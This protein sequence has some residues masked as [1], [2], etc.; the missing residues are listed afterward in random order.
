MS[1][2]NSYNPTSSAF[3]PIYEKLKH[4]ADNPLVKQF[5]L[6]SFNEILT[7]EHSFQKKALAQEVKTEDGKTKKKMYEDILETL[8]MLQIQ[9]IQF[10][11][12]LMF[13]SEESAPTL[14]IEAEEVDGKESKEHGPA[15]KEVKATLNVV[16]DTTDPKQKETSAKESPVIDAE[17]NISETS[18][19]PIIAL[20]AF[21]IED[22]E[23]K[24]IM[25]GVIKQ[26]ETEKN[27][28]DWLKDMVTNDMFLEGSRIK[29]VLTRG[30]GDER[31]KKYVAQFL[32]NPA[33]EPEKEVT[34]KSE[35]K[36]IEL[37]EKPISFNKM[38]EK[39]KAAFKDFIDDKVVTDYVNQMI[40]KKL[41][42]GGSNKVS[43][44]RARKDWITNVKNGVENSRKVNAEAEK[45][46]AKSDMKD[47]SIETIL[48]E[49]KEDVGSS[50][51]LLQACQSA[52]NELKAGNRDKAVGIIKHYLGEYGGEAKGTF[53][54]LDIQRLLNWIDEDT[55][56]HRSPMDLLYNIPL[57]L[58]D[59]IKEVERLAKIEGMGRK[60]VQDL[61]F[62]KVDGVKMREHKTDDDIIRD[63]KE[64]NEWFE[65]M[66]GFVFR[67][68]KL[69]NEL[70]DQTKFEQ[71]FEEVI[72]NAGSDR[73]VLTQLTKQ[74]K[75]GAEKFGSQLNLG[76]ALK[77]VRSKLEALN[78]ELKAADDE[79]KA[80]SKKGSNV[81]DTTPSIALP[82][83]TQKQPVENESTESAKSDK[84]GSSEKDNSGN[85][86]SD[87]KNVSTKS[88]QRS[89]SER[90]KPI[91]N[92]AKKLK[93]LKQLTNFILQN[94]KVGTVD[95]YELA[96][97]LITSNRIKDAVTTF[98]EGEPPVVWDLQQI[99]RWYR[100]GPAKVLEA[101]DLFHAKN[102]VAFKAALQKY[103][104]KNS[105]LEQNA[106]L[107]KVEE[108]IVMDVYIRS[109]YV[110]KQAKHKDMKM[111]LRKLYEEVL[112]E[113]HVHT[114]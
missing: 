87:A 104:T 49:I 88:E 23:V 107:E 100:L 66:C 57:S 21:Q 60:D 62:S 102:T 56:H 43:D 8:E 47:T 64:F 31:Y 13:N 91:W 58:T 95:L 14:D 38:K 80:K 10:T 77:I 99:S 93:N 101:I 97:E 113:N 18:I 11:A 41:I 68:D 52:E 33:K 86:S 54:D 82:A 78:P 19:E 48:P 89:F 36:K 112:E 111:N 4:F 22:K 20:P 29:G 71:E 98:K 114:T 59:V 9:S 51:E 106:L 50:P 1:K 74:Y 30:E 6:K 110:G 15:T 53:S 32:K 96:R 73:K 25:H 28:I 26:G 46:A 17:T 75:E 108:L 63:K 84:D 44:K 90:N 40:H 3:A 16:R 72:R 2:E 79:H 92:K 45:V 103:I 27:L 61:I 76:D 34:S 35:V 85:G 67:N 109:N 105:A 81:S 5:A 69:K 83:S 12:D 7:A 42:K 39:V 24:A 37:P 94:P 70:K 55:F 65:R